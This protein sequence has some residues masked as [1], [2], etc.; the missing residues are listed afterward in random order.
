LFTG[1][2]LLGEAINV[3]NEGKMKRDFTYIDD[4]AEG[5][6]RV[7]D[8]TATPNPDYD[9]NVSDPGTSYAPYRVYNIGN[10]DVVQLRDFIELLSVKKQKKI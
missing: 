2:I 10:N 8:I 5:V 4:I 1:A 6:V 7:I 9:I 3:F